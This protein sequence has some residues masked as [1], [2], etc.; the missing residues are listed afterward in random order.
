[1]LSP[2]TLDRAF[3]RRLRTLVRNVS[4]E[5]I[6]RI[7]GQKH[8][9]SSITITC[10]L[11]GAPQIGDREPHQGDYARADTAE[12]WTSRVRIA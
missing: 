11:S 3:G 6:G 5:A 12:L 4:I 9:A 8:R 1:M 2:A 10:P 7:L